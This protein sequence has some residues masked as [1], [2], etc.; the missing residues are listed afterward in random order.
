MARGGNFVASI[1]AASDYA[2]VRTQVALTRIR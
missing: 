1:F 2:R